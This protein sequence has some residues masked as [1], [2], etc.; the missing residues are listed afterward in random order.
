MTNFQTIV[1]LDN[2][3]GVNTLGKC[4]PDKTLQEYKWTRDIVDKLI[5]EF[6][7]IGIKAIKLVPEDIDISLKERVE[8]VNQIYKDNNKQAILISIHCNA[9][10]S[11]ADWKNARGWSVYISPNA[12]SKSKLLAKLLYEEAEKE[13]LKGNRYVPKEKYWTQSLYICSKTNC[14]AVLT[15]NLFQDNKEDVKFLLSEEGKNKIIKIH[16]QGVLKYLQEQ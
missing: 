14:P 10:G 1:I 11:G 7:K 12:S 5:I 16:I 4:S 6:E 3:H 15:E 2:G 9:A 8:R 13:N